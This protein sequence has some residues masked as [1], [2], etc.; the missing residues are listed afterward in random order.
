MRCLQC[1]KEIPE[2]RKFCSRSCSASY[3]NVKRERKPWTEEQKEKNRKPGKEVVCKYCGK[4]G[5]KVCDECKPYVQRVRTFNKLGI[6]GANLYVKNQKL[7]KILQDLYFT[8][9]LSLAEIWEKTGLRY[10]QVEIIFHTAG[11]SL[12]SVSDCQINALTTGRRGIPG[13]LEKRGIRGYHETWQGS[14][15]WY[16]SSY[17]L[18]FAELLDSQKIPYKVEAKEA[19]TRYWDSE[20]QRERVAVPD[21]YLPET[22]EIVEVK[23][24]YTLGSIQRMKE[25][26]EAY[27]QRGFTPKLWLNFKFIDDIEKGSGE[28]ANQEP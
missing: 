22:N 26:F 16:R 15:V 14:K 23:S 7:L 10:H 12:R 17:E 27:R 25:K 8:Q 9:H 28:S 13:P 18:A 20:L 6:E 3:N 4:P 21:F 19:R 5:K 24:S 1:G 2:G 11:I